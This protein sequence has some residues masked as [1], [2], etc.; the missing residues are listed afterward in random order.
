MTGSVGEL[1]NAEFGKNI[2]L[3]STEMLHKYLY[4]YVVQEG[5]KGQLKEGFKVDSVF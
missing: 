4:Q 3:F 2:C 5:T 1:R